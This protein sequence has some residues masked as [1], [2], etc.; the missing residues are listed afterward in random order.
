MFRKICR[1]Q[2]IYCFFFWGTFRH[3]MR[4]R[5]R[6]MTIAR[7]TAAPVPS[8]ATTSGVLY[9]G[10]GPQYTQPLSSIFHKGPFPVSC[11]CILIIIF[12][13]FFLWS[14]QNLNIF[15]NFFVPFYHELYV[16]SHVQ[17]YAKKMELL[18]QSLKQDQHIKKKDFAK[19]KHL[20][21][22]FKGHILALTDISFSS[23]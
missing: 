12:I 2:V 4:K 5:E 13:I 21:K 17:W 3:F 11:K 19:Q 9:Q 10:L 22:F 14:C 23:S 6:K 1:C 16:L 8:V 18:L 20:E 7:L 15:C